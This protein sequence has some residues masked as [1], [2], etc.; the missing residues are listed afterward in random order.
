MTDGEHFRMLDSTGREIYSAQFDPGSHLK[1]ADRDCRL[2]ASIPAEQVHATVT[3]WAAM[4]RGL[5][6]AA[7]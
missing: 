1:V 7:R 5:Q 4:A 6:L 3:T 2:I